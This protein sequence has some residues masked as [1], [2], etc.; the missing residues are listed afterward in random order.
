[1]N[2]MKRLGAWV[3]LFLGLGFCPQMAGASDCAP[4]PAGLVS[5]WRGEGNADDAVGS[6][7][8]QLHNGASFAP[9]KV[10]QGFLFD[11]M[12]DF[13]LVPDSPSLDLTNEITVEMWFK[14]E[15]WA[16]PIT[17]SLIDKRTWNDCNYG[18]VVSEQWGF[19]L[20]YDDPTVGPSF[21]I[22]ATFPLPATDV[23]HHFAGTYR[24]VDPSQIELKTYLD[25]VL[26]RTEMLPGNLA[27]AVNDMAVTIG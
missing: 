11:G 13:V 4:V 8:G 25:G 10:G 9:G 23:F 17:Y 12:D 5:W 19:Q 20:Y 22:S 15:T 1:M 6:N 3:S 16:D 14:S 2:T 24:Q 7:H 21:E 26:V 18:A 27:N